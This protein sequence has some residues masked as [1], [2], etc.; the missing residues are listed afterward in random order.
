MEP[1]IDLKIVV[2]GD[3]NAGKTSMLSSYC[4]D[5]FSMAY[6]PTGEIIIKVYNLWLFL[7]NPTSDKFMALFLLMNFRKKNLRLGRLNS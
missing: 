4:K 5:R 7:W 3:G 2:V 1:E 6:Q